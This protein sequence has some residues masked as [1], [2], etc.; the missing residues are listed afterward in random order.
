M[1]LWLEPVASARLYQA[2]HTKVPLRALL[3][4]I[5]PNILSMHGSRPRWRPKGIGGTGSS[6]LQL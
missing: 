1:L 6:W 3:N 2:H 5:T 4:S